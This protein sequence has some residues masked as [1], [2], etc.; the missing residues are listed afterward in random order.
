[1]F[2][3]IKTNKIWPTVLLTLASVLIIYLL[4]VVSNMMT[5]S[6][7]ERLENVIIDLG[8]KARSVNTDFK[9]VGIDD[10]IIVALDNE[11]IEKLGKVQWWPRKYD[12]KVISNIS[13]GNPKSIGIDFLYTE[14]DTLPEVYLDLLREKGIAGPGEILSA[15]STDKNLEDS[16]AFSGKVYLSFYDDHD[17]EV[18]ES[19]IGLC[20]EY[21]D[22]LSLDGVNDDNYYELVHPV[23]PVK[24]LAYAAKGVGAIEMPSEKDGI[25]RKYIL[26]QKL[27]TS[28]GPKYV[29]NFPF[30]MWADDQDFGDKFTLNGEMLTTDGNDL[31]KINENGTLWINWLGTQEEI[32][33]VSFHKV[34]SG[35]VSPEVF[36]NK[37]VFIG[38]SASGLSDLK[39]VPYLDEQIPGVDIHAISFLNFMNRK[40]VVKVSL[41]MS[42]LFTIISVLLLTFGFMNLRSFLSLGLTLLFVGFILGG[43]L[44]WYFPSTSKIFPITSLML[45]AFVS[46]ILTMVYRYFTEEK[47]KR[48][49]RHAFSRYVSSTVVDKIL[50][51][52]GS[53]KLGGTK[54]NLTV[55]FSDI[56]GFTSYSEKLDPQNLVAIL[57]RYL[58]SMSEPI[59]NYYG[60]IDKFIGD[61]IF[62]IFGAPL[63]TDEHA[64]QACF[65]AL[66]MIERLKILNKELEEENLLPLEIGIGI[67]T[68]EMTVGNVGSS[69][70]FDYT[71]IGDSVNLGS[72]IEGLT[73]Y[74]NC[75][76]LISGDTW[77]TCSQDKFLARKLAK[78][79]VYGKDKFV[80][81]YQLID[82]KKNKE[83]YEPWL[84]H[85]ESGMKSFEQ[86]DFQLA[87]QS[88]VE[89]NNQKSNDPLTKEYIARSQRF[90]LDPDSFDDVIDMEYK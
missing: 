28:V 75:G 30:Y 15:I 62:A 23:M 22:C 44:L 36:K 24:E 1:V 73:R 51:D 60:T 55:L 47:E 10:V 11:S 8:Y 50:K 74:Y 63:D 69:K 71:A 52:P 48:Q 56:K 86:L 20:S 90:E 35:L 31:F 17:K 67:N 16:L 33:H 53:L 83:N 85:W 80:M 6:P 70:R 12:A 87:L 68:G 7:L 4:S 27:N 38:A 65:V 72:R 58:D 79:K 14:A 41:A 32:R 29:G 81:I 78:V 66:E 45:T 26:F 9:D 43:Y 2:R 21:L 40:P 18:S 13:K 34:L 25:I 39:S 42:T 77:N 88:F 89:C 64:D 3:K 19:N 61:A 59:L 82:L 37:Y 5:Y 84:T 49:L 76:I 46:F 57:N 54:R